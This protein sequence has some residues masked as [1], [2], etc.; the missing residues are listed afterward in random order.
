[1]HAM[2]EAICCAKYDCSSDDMFI[3]CSLDADI[4]IQQ[5]HE[6]ACTRIHNQSI[7]ELIEAIITITFLANYFNSFIFRAELLHLIWPVMH[8]ILKWL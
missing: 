7:G 5:A 4:A 6:N 1:M 2:P 3:G 8:H